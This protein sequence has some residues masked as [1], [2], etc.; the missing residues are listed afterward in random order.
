[1]P[2][3]TEIIGSLLIKELIAIRTDTLWRML[4]LLKRDQLPEV[5]EEGATGKLDNKGAIFIPGGL[6]YQD[7]DEKEIDYKPQKLDAALFRRIIR[8][9]LKYDNATLLFDDGVVNSVNLD[10]GFFTRTTRVIYTAKA[11]AHK[12]TRRV[13][14]TADN[15]IDAMDIIRSHCPSYVTPPYGSRTRIS[16]CVSVGLIDPH[17]YFAYCK[18]ECNLSKEHLQSFAARLNAVLE[19]PEKSEGQILFP[20]YV[21]VCHD[22]RYKENSLTGL[23]RILGIGKF[24]EFATITF[25]SLGSHLAAEMRRK[26]IDQTQDHVFAEY[27]GVK[28]LCVLRTYEQTNPG[29][30]SLKYRLDLISAEKDLGLDLENIGSQARKRYGIKSERPS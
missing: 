18:R 25:E 23:I 13:S 2:S 8:E 21:V 28:A 24:G 19:P 7:V 30:R 29:K 14:H 5:N 26:D 16:T 1:M 3:K 20:P 15:D 4:A 27:D 9:S 12:R 6:I 10:T 17:M 22:T 11:A